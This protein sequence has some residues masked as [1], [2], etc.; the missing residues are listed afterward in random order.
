MPTP[1]IIF[2]AEPLLS[3]NSRLIIPGEI[4][5]RESS[6]ERSFACQ[7]ACFL[8]FK[9][10]YPRSAVDYYAFSQLEIL[11]I[12]ATGELIGRPTRLT[13]K[14]SRLINEIKQ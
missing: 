4:I 13:V 14:G 5:C 2:D 1:T 11:K 10:A 9:I 8:L 12:E 6:I 3:G 7:I